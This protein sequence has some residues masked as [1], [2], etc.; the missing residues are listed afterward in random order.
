M[1]KKLNQKEIAYKAGS[2]ITPTAPNPIWNPISQQS[3]ASPFSNYK[4]DITPKNMPTQTPNPQA[5]LTNP[6]VFRNGDTGYL[7]GITMPNG[8]SFLGLK[9]RE[10]QAMASQYQQNTAL[11]QGTQLAGTAQNALDT[12]LQNQQIIEQAQKGLLTQDQISS[13]QGAKTDYGQ[14]IGAGVV[15]ATPGVLSGAGLGGL[16]AGAVVGGTIGSVVPVVGT[17]IGAGIGAVAGAAIGSFI[18]G[19]KG[20]IAQQQ[21]EEFTKDQNALSKGTA[22][23]RLLTADIKANPQNAAQ[24]AELFYKTLNMIDAAHAKTQKDSQENLNKW[25][26]EDGAAQLAK[27]EVFDAVTRQYYIQKLQTVLINPTGSDET[28]S[29]D[30]LVLMGYTGEGTTE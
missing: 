20:N 4:V 14:A 29:M 17:A 8:N 25:L 28:I 15:G 26:G 30:D 7:S 21:A 1:A 9:P 22:T 23:L 13:I 11:P 10:V 19:V 2:N 16:G 5:K 6:E 24:D 27:F 3:N 18:R 12:Q